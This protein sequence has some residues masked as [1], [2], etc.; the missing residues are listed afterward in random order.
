MKSRNTLPSGD[1]WFVVKEGRPIARES[2]LDLAIIACLGHR[3]DGVTD[4]LDNP[5]AFIDFADC[6][7]TYNYWQEHKEDE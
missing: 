7:E 3:A 2:Y 1:H 6:K 5:A 4:D